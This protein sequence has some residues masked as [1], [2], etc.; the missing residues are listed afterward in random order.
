MKKIIGIIGAVIG[1]VVI[2]LA[3]GLYMGEEFSLKYP[4]VKTDTDTTEVAIDSV[5]LT[6]GCSQFRLEAFNAT[7]ETIKSDVVVM[8]KRTDG[9]P[10]QKNDEFIVH[11]VIDN[12][13]K[14]LLKDLNDTDIVL[15]HLAPATAAASKKLLECN[16]YVTSIRFLPVLPDNYYTK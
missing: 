6:R 13:L 11:A 14:Y 3:V 9:K 12:E 2:M 7:N 4:F 15:E 1:I 5:V 16:I 10:V 8:F